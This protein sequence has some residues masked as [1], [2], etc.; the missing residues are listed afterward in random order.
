MDN[1]FQL[2]MPR[3]EYALLG[4]KRVQAR[5]AE[6]PK[7]R[8]SVTIEIMRSLKSA[9]MSPFPTPDRLMLW[10]AACTGFFEVHLNLADVAVD[11]HSAPSMVWVK[12]KQSKTDPFRLGMDVY[13][14]ATGADVCPV[15]A[16]IQYLAI[17]VSTPGPLF[18]NQ[19]GSPLTRVGLVSHPHTALHQAGISP[20][21]YNWHSFRIGA[22]TTA[23]R[24][25][26]EDSLIKTLG[27]RKSSAYQTYI[28][29]PRHE[30]AAAAKSLVCNLQNC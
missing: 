14:G 20:A 25:G 15:Q 26:M 22:S 7:Q 24:C 29:I 12:V 1:P 6:P 2:V 16:I 27:R 5:Q 10:A 13:L 23:A 11:S 8:L 9:W 30:L 28:R 17:R 3:L 4:I 21:N 18:I 19:V